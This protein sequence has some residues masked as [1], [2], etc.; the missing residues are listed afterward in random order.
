[1]AALASGRG[2]TAVHMAAAIM[3]G[4]GV[5]GFASTSALAGPPFRTDDPVPVDYQHGEL[6]LFA[7]GTQAKGTNEGVAPGIEANYGF[8]PNAMLHVILPGAYSREDGHANWGYGD[9][10]IGIKY[11][12]LDAGP[13]GTGLMAGIFPLVVVPT[14]DENQGI[15]GGETQV[16]LPLWLQ[17]DFGPWTTYGG[18]GYW[19]NPGSGNQDYWFAGWLL[20]RQVTDHLV[21]GGEVFYQS[22]D[23]LDGVGSTGF[24]LGGIYDFSPQHH[25]LFSAG[26]GI[27]NASETNSFS[28]YLG[29]QYTF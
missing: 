29:Y 1:M 21:L 27:Q 6:Y 3:L 20:Q 16:F 26:T 13:E 15:G 8:T 22:A 17:K 24:N 12:F 5:G 2:E 10:E 25:L 9:T 7:S 18:G 14:G 4:L 28:Y 19:V 11:R 23:T